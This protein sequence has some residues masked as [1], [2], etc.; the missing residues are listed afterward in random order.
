MEKK[1]YKIA[2]AMGAVSVA[3]A[4]AFGIT[5]AVPASVAVS[6]ALLG[7]AAYCTAMHAL[8]SLYRN[9]RTAAKAESAAPGSVTSFARS[10]D[11][12]QALKP[13][14]LLAK[15][16]RDGVRLSVGG[17]LRPAEKTRREGAV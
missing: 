5:G 17:L 1:T 13:R 15:K 11:E 9:Y 12:P 8:L 10:A 4:A 14:A 7:C 16:T 3:L 6:C 2:A